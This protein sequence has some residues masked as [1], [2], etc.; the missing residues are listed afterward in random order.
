MDAEQFAFTALQALP[1]DPNE[2]QMA[3]LALCRAS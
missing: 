3:V 1:Y 2:Q